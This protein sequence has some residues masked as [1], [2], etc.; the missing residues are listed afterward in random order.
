MSA[1]HSYPLPDDDAYW[2]RVEE[3]QRWLNELSFKEQCKEEEEAQQAQQSEQE[4]LEWR[5][6]M[7]YEVVHDGERMVTKTILDAA[8]RERLDFVQNLIR[9]MDAAAERRTKEEDLATQIAEL[10]KAREQI[11]TR[12]ESLT[13]QQRT[14]RRDTMLARL[15]GPVRIRPEDNRNLKK[16]TETNL[17]R[18]NYHEHRCKEEIAAVR[19]KFEHGRKYASISFHELRDMQ[20]A[21]HEA[22]LCN[23]KLSPEKVEAL[24]VMHN[25]KLENIAHKF[26]YQQLLYSSER[27]DQRIA[28]IKHRRNELSWTCPDDGQAYPFYWQGREYHRTYDN[29]VWLTENWEWQGYWTGYYIARGMEPHDDEVSYEIR[30]T[31]N[32]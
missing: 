20:T 17:S 27:E 2:A 31:L 7:Q 22:R 11:S 10:Q 32:S 13:A 28:E 21:K 19:Q 3:N 1:T 8:A 6:S 16:E 24:T 18:I 23:R 26:S 25:R 5:A 29:E 12:L 30:E 9:C 15:K 4:Y 14:A